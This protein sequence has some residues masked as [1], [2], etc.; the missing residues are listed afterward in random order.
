MLFDLGAQALAGLK[1]R[2]AFGRLP[3]QEE[4][5]RGHTQYAKLHGQIGVLVYV[6]LAQFQLAVPQAGK[7]FEDRFELFAR[8]TPL[9]AEL[10]Q[11][12]RR[13]GQD[14]GGECICGE[15]NQISHSPSTREPPFGESKGRGLRT[16][17]GRETPRPDNEILPS[18]VPV[19]HHLLP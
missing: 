13:R 7:F 16:Q 4:D 9:G 12:R 6:N 15:M 5:Q 2:Q 17:P 8:M 14:L 18:S 11:H 3:C 19:C 10:D 1:A